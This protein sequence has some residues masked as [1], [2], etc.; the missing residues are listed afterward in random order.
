MKEDFVIKKSECLL[1]LGGKWGSY[2]YFFLYVS[3][4]KMLI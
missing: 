1:V 2:F 4:V 3:H